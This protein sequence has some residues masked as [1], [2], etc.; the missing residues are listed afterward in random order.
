MVISPNKLIEL[1]ADRVIGQEAAKRT[2]AVALKN[3]WRDTKVC[4]DNAQEPL[5]KNVILLGTCGVGKSTLIKESSNILNLPYCKV[6]LPRYCGEKNMDDVINRLASVASKKLEGFKRDLNTPEAQFDFRYDFD[7]GKQMLAEIEQVMKPINNVKCTTFKDVYN[8]QQRDEYIRLTS[9]VDPRVRS[10]TS[11]YHKSIYMLYHGVLPMEIETPFIDPPILA[12]AK[13]GFVKILEKYKSIFK[14]D[15]EY[16]E[17]LQLQPHHY[18]S[19]YGVVELADFDKLHESYHKICSFILDL[20]SHKSILTKYGL[21]DTKHILFILNISHKFYDDALDKNI[22]NMFPIRV[23]LDDL[24]E[25]DYYRILKSSKSSVL[26]RYLKLLEIDNIKVNVTDEAIREIAKCAVK[27]G[28]LLSLNNGGNVLTHLIHS[29]FAIVAQ[30]KLGNTKNKAVK[31]TIDDKYI[32][33]I[34]KTAIDNIN[35]L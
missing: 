35:V 24:K 5:P 1:L 29:M 13:L 15:D 12:K 8:Q 20:N 6:S 4:K 31:I 3:R 22:L 17:L 26:N 2:L 18:A 21:V 25:D 11:E 16:V 32:K 10:I 19:N 33:S 14:L 23:A 9:A 27:V 30:D 34:S 7:K 28:K